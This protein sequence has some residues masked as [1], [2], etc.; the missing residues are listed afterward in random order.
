ERRSVLRQLPEI[1][2]Q[3]AQLAVQMRSLHADTLRQLS[4]L[5]IAQDQLLLQVGA[6][7]MLARFSQGQRQQILLHQGLIGRRVS[8]ELALDLVQ[9]DFFFAAQDQQSLH[10]ISQL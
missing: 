8:G 4:D 5:A 3:G 1:D 7:E 9:L 2:A 6:L 10:E